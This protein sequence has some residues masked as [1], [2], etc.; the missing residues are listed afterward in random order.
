MS[1][2][3]HYSHRYRLCMGET[4]GSLVSNCRMYRRP[5][6]LPTGT[7]FA[8]RVALVTG[9]NRGIG[10]HICHLLVQHK[11]KR[12]IIACRDVRLGDA[13][14]DEIRQ[15]F[16]EAT[17]E[18]VVYKLDLASRESIQEFADEIRSKEPQ[19]DYLINNAA[20]LCNDRRDSVNGDEM[21]IAVNY[22]GT[23]L[24]TMLLLD[25]VSKTA[26]DGRIL[27][28]SS[29]AHTE[30]RSLRIHDLS[31]RE[32]KSFPFFQVYGHTK[33]ALLLFV[34]KLA[35]MAKQLNVLSYAVNPGVSQTDLGRES[36]KRFSL[37]PGAIMLR[38]GLSRP[39]MR[40]VAEAA[41]SVLLPLTFARQEYEVS[42]YNWNEGA[43]QVVSPAARDRETADRLW[44]LTADK[45]A[46]PLMHNNS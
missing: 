4:F 39:F 14:A 16:P 25:H 40:S 46:L 9:G 29:I 32:G 36:N 37:S 18:I 45:L 5:R 7:S 42:K 23:V 41:T 11:A 17:S 6:S 15:A 10:L 31:W 21:M 12:L 44:S 2:L 28:V 1:I 26:T 8:D 22:F 24:L 19:L 3:Q 35:P 30:V 20:I 38:G 34:Q 13:A 33:L 27:F 43:F